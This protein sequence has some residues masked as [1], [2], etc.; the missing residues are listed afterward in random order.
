MVRQQYSRS[1]LHSRSVDG[2]TLYF[3]CSDPHQMSS[4]SDFVAQLAVRAHSVR[5]G[6]PKVNRCK[7]RASLTRRWLALALSVWSARSSAKTDSLVSVAR[8]LLPPRLQGLSGIVERDALRIRVTMFLEVPSAR[9][10]F[11]MVML[12]ILCLDNCPLQE[13]IVR[14]TPPSGFSTEELSPPDFPTSGALGH[15]DTH[16]FCGTEETVE[17]TKLNPRVTTCRVRRHPLILLFFFPV[18][19]VVPRRVPYI[20]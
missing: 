6:D 18:L 20:S 5:C 12:S 14:S 4:N 3:L 11:Q 1:D 9:V 8:P 15:M 16:N 19:E 13:I 10:F 7:R 2:A 17:D